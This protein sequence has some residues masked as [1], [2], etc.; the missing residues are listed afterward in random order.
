MD[1]QRPPAATPAEPPPAAVARRRPAGL[2]ATVLV[3]LL[4]GLAGAALV[5]VV[6]EA[7]EEDDGPPATTTGADDGAGAGTSVRSWA[8][9]VRAAR[10]GVVSIT[11]TVLVDAPAPPGFE[12]PG[13]Q[14]E[15]STGS[16]FVI[17]D[18]GTI[19]TNA[20]VVAGAT[21]VVI[22]LADG[23]TAR[24][25]LVGSDT[26]TD[27]AVL[28]VDLPEE[29]LHPLTLGSAE[30]VAVG[31]PV[32][33][34]GDPFGY[35]GS[36][37][38]GIVSGLE[39]EISAP[40]G[41]TITD[42]IQT[43]AALNHG[44]SGGPLLDAAGR[45][46]GVSA[47]LASSGVDA[48]V[49]VAF[50]VPIDD[51]TRKVLG[52]LRENGVASHVWLGIAGQTIQPELVATGEVE[53]SSGVLVTGVAPDSPA[54]AAGMRAGSTTIEAGGVAYCVGGDVITA[55]DGNA[56]PGVHELQDVLEELEPGDEAVLDVVRP[57]GSKAKLRV[58]LTKQPEEPPALQSGC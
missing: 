25:T 47:Q 44:N 48:N 58:E 37:S 5:L 3:A 50:A 46:I 4:A 1:E 32:L 51:H 36:A 22:R 26:T 16:G 10:Q 13:K 24:A 9:V 11:A 34:I 19:A 7:R 6:E 17:D 28:S 14:E 42:A 31:Q 12:S 38:A 23:T 39:R 56:T 33:A 45:V 20:H 40:N 18:D 15:T 2:L 27:L 53:A 35:E 29:D 8:P 54:A 49:G 55:I 43:D 21:A 57:D 41:W 30:R 52:E